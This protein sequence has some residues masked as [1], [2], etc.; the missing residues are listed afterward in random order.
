MN[1]STRLMAVIAI[2][3]LVFIAGGCSKSEKVEQGPKMEMASAEPALKIAYS[4]WPGW[5]AWDIGIQKGFFEEAGV[6]V[7]FR[8]F[9]YVPSMDAFAAGQVDAVTMTNGDALITGALGAPS[10]MILVN[11]YSNGN[12]LIVANPGI[13]SV[14]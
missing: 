8:W 14:A 4:D 9:E 7:D 10:I 2:I 6:A 11:D 12:D 13:D 3:A 5:I 1:V